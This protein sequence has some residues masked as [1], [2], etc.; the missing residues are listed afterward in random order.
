MDPQEGDNKEDDPHEPAPQHDADTPS[1]LNPEHAESRAESRANRRGPM[2]EMRQ[3]LRIMVKVLPQS[4]KF[5]PKDED[6]SGNKVTES[7]IK[8]YLKRT[9][10]EEAPQPEWGLPQGWGQYL[11]GE[12]TGRRHTRM[13]RLVFPM[14]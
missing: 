2:D 5:V 1:M 13:Q 6:G 12:W 11:A 7:Q 9:L 8:L 3:F 4:M 10:G 14:P